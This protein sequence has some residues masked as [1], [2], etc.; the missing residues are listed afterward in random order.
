MLKM[1]KRISNIEKTFDALH[2]SIGL[3][4][5]SKSI[6]DAGL[7]PIPENPEAERL[8]EIEIEEE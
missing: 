6:A 1:E 8:A 3:E 4:T 7:E 2:K 5:L